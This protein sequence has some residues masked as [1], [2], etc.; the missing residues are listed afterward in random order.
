MLQ[1]TAELENGIPQNLP[2]KLFQEK[3]ILEAG[4]RIFNL[5]YT[6]GKRI[7]LSLNEFL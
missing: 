7:L 2:E 3:K 6:V 5:H 1:I 4:Y